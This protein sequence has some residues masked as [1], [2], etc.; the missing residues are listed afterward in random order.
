MNQSEEFFNEVGL[1]FG[2]MLLNIHF[3]KWNQ[4]HE[5]L[6]DSHPRSPHRPNPPTPTYPSSSSVFVLIAEASRVPPMFAHVSTCYQKN[7]TEPKIKKDKEEEGRGEI[8]DG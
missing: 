4:N 8:K 3:K 7:R 2:H 1:L 6:Y 5:I